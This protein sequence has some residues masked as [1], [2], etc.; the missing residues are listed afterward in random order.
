MIALTWCSQTSAH[1]QVVNAKCDECN[2]R[3]NGTKTHSR[4]YGSLHYSVRLDMCVCVLSSL[5]LFH[6]KLNH[7]SGFAVERMIRNRNSLVSTSH[8]ASV[9][10]NRTNMKTF[11]RTKSILAAAKAIERIKM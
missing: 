4:F 5:W 11:N 1:L 7:F 10:E 2:E 9:S 6:A 8:C 3:M